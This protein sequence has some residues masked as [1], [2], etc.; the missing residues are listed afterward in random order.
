[1]GFANSFLG[2]SFLTLWD[3]DCEFLGCRKAFFTQ[4]RC[5]QRTPLHLIPPSHTTLKEETRREEGKRERERHRKR[6]RESEIEE[7]DKNS[8]QV[9]EIDETWCDLHSWLFATTTS[10]A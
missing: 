8:H 7:T 2:E 5:L 10:S 9:L 4:G 1:M 3:G 6:E